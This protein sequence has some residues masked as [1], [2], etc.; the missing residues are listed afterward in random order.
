M[1]VINIADEHGVA[2]HPPLLRLNDAIDSKSPDIVFSLCFVLLLY[3]RLK[4]MK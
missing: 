3:V 4:R 2:S 1:L